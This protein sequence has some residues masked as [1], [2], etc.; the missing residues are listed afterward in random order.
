VSKLEPKAAVSP[1]A[2]LRQYYGPDDERPGYVNRLFDAAA[3]HYEWVNRM[4]SLG[5][6]QAYRRMALERAGLRPSSRLLDIASGT[7]LVLRAASTIVGAQGLAI[8]LDPSAGMLRESKALRPLPLVQSR[9]ETLPFASGSF[10]FVSLG[11]G[12]R[13]LADL[14]VLFRECS[15]VLRPGGRILVLEF[16]RPRSQV[17]LLFS[18]FYLKTLV[19]FV[20][21]L[22][23][24]SP[25]AEEV[26]RYCWDTVDQVVPAETVL[27]S[28]G[29]AGFRDTTRRGVFGVFV[30]YAGVKSFS[31]A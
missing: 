25:Q 7:G 31:L 24:R 6:G 19:P 28:L 12:L 13:H 18:R 15:R 27:G 20:T 29:R 16:S 11:Y 10:D 1:H 30:E 17:G 9:G 5:S 26:M 23:T 21:R 22:G 2:P 14:D 3:P 4:M 8:G